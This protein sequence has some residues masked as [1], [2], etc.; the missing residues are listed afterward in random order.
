L[1]LFG[2]TPFRKWKLSYCLLIDI[3]NWICSFDRYNHQSSF[4]AVKSKEINWLD[5]RLFTRDVVTKAKQVVANHNES[6]ILVELVKSIV[7]QSDLLSEMPGSA[8]KSTAI[9]RN[10]RDNLL[11]YI[12]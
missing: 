8:V 3:K 2:Y 10:Y 6:A 1:V 12:R 4:F 5:I 11:E 9:D 7:S